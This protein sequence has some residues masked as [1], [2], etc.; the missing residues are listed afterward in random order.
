MEVGN[1][2]SHLST[3]E[4]GNATVLFQCQ[5]SYITEVSLVEWTTGGQS[6]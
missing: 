1:Y 4:Q 2:F 6:P 5:F 3:S